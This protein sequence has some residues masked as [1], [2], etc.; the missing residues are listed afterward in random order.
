M[1]ELGESCESEEEEE[2]E[3]EEQHPCIC[4]GSLKASKGQVGL[5]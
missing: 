1:S 5:Y 3:E 4:L 2:E